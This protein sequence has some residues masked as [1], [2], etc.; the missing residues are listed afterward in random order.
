M[1]GFRGG[2]RYQSVQPDDMAYGDEGVYGLVERPVFKSCKPGFAHLRELNRH[3]ARLSYLGQL[4]LL[5]PMRHLLA[6]K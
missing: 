4:G 5:I 6:C 2:T 3:L 1:I